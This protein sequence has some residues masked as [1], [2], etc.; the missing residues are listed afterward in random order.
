MLE[1]QSRQAGKP[2]WYG[3]DDLMLITHPMHFVA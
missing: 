2:E 3:H 1:P